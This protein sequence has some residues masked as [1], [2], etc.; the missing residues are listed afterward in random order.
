MRPAPEAEQFLGLAAL[1]FGFYLRTEQH[2]F[3]H[4]ACF[5]L[6]SL[7]RYKVGGDLPERNYVLLCALLRTVV[8]LDGHNL[9]I[10]ARHHHLL[11]PSDRKYT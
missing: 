1:G 11:K 10:L 9:S 5:L 4:I 6:L 2:D 3:C 7:V 8:V